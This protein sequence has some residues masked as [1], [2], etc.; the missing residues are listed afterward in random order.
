MKALFKPTT[1]MLALSMAVGLSACGEK[2]ASTSTSTEN[3][4][5]GEIATAKAP[6]GKDTLVIVNDAEPSSLDPQKSQDTNGSAIIRQMM[7]G[8][9][10]T[11]A[12]GKTVPGLAESWETPDNKVW[13]FKLRDAKW[14]NGD[15]ITAH[16]AVFALR[17]L[18]DPNTAA[19]YASYLADAKVLGAADIANGKA[20]VETLGVKALDD[21]TLEIT[22]TEAVPYFVDMLTLPVAYPVHQKSLEAHGDK[23]LDPKNI[24]VSGAYKL[25][26]W[27]VGS[28]ITLER[29]PNYYN[30]D[31][32]TIEKAQFLPITAQNG[33]NRYRAGEVDIS[34]VPGEQLEKVKGETPNEVQTSPKLC[35]YYLEPNVAAKPLD[36][37]RVRQALS[38]AVEREMI[39]K[40]LK[41]GEPVAYQLTP[42]AVQGMTEVAPEWKA[43]DQAARNE[44]AKAL[45]AEAGYTAENPLKFEFLYSTSE[46]GKL[47]SNAITSMWKQNLGGAVDAAQINQEWKTFL[48]TKNQ[49][50]FTMAFSG[51][52]AD[53]NEPSSFLNLL[54]TGNSNNTG[55]YS[56]PQ[57]DTLLA[58]TLK[59]DTTPEARQQLY[60]EAELLISKDTAII[61]VYSAISVRLIKP[62]VQGLSSKDPLDG[63]LVKDISFNK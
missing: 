4:T 21:K 6:D 43:L 31:K 37:T 29:N 28:H 3:S 40:I 32:T 42:M 2:Q 5:A 14:S 50:K 24:V 51:W 48:D 33:I 12:E 44:K 45:L 55:K 10:V 22:L 27:A 36:D 25:S 61:P 8:L 26:E 1:M 58:D 49:G 47:L 17:R 59:A 56:N 39:V 54:K 41:R 62:Y 11:D 60:K 20:P 35:T 34:K 15:A 57:F 30:N 7:E 13:T 23:W 52:C 53:Y 46:T 63:Y 19:Y 9:V 38:M 16:D 18:V